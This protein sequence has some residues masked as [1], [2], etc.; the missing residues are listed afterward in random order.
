MSVA[1]VTQRGSSSSP[2]FSGFAW[3]TCSF[4]TTA[5]RPSTTLAV[6][7]LSHWCEGNGGSLD[8]RLHELLVSYAADT[9]GLGLASREG[10]LRDD[11]RRRL[12]TR[13]TRNLNTQYARTAYRL[14][15]KSIWKT[16]QLR[17]TKWPS[18]L[19]EIT[20]KLPGDGVVRL[21]T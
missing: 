15:V 7:L 10:A 3:H 17:P 1:S 19:I 2:C 9:G 14:I 12:R 6:S 8:G 5:V 21:W 20:L 13:L 18:A 16:K 4:V 11:P